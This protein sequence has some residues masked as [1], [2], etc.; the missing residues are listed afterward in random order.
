MKILFFDLKAFGPFTDKPIDLSKGSEGFHIIYGPNEAGKS[1][2]LRAIR[3]LFYG[4]HER[5]PD[6][7]L[8][9]G[10]KLRIGARIKHSDGSELIFQRRKGRT[11]TLL[12]END[13]PLDER[14]LERFLGGIDEALFAK[15]FGI[16]YDD[17][18]QGG[19]EIIAGHGDIGES[20]FAA[21]LGKGGLRKVLSE[22]DD[23]TDALFKPQA[24]KRYINIKISEFQEAKKETQKASLSSQDWDTHQRNL[25][26]AQNQKGNFVGRPN[27]LNTELNHLK[28]L[29]DVLP[30]LG[31]LKET[32]NKRTSM[33]DVLILSPEFPQ[34]RRDALQT[35]N[36]AKADA[37]KAQKYMQTYRLEL[38]QIHIPKN[39]I[40]MESVIK[41]L[42]Q[43]LGSH[44]KAKKDL[45]N[46]LTKRSQLLSDAE[47]I[48]RD[49]RPDITIEKVESIRISAPRR[50][51]IHELSSQHGILIEKQGNATKQHAIIIDKIDQAKKELETLGESKDIGE[52][53]EL[54][55]FIR[56]QGDMEKR[57]KETRKELQTLDEQ[58]SIDLRKLPLWTRDLDSL[59]ALTTPQQETIDRFEKSMSDQEMRLERIKIAANNAD[60][61]IKELNAD[62]QSLE[63]VGEIPTEDDLLRARERRQKG[64]ELIR[65]TWME[66][67]SVDAE[68]SVFDSSLPLDAAYEKSV[69]EADEISDRLRREADRVAQKTTWRAELKQHE[70]ELINYRAEEGIIR[71]GMIEIN[72]QWSQLWLPLGIQPLSP[73]E[74]RPWLISQQNLV[75][76]SERVRNAR[77]NVS[78]IEKEI[79]DFKSRLLTVFADLGE[80]GHSKVQSL[81]ILSNI[82]NKVITRHDETETQREFS[83]KILKDSQAQLKSVGDEKDNANTK[84]TQWQNEWNKVIKGIGFDVFIESSVVSSYIER[85]QQLF[86]KIDEASKLSDRIAGIERDENR[87]SSDVKAIVETTAPDLL[88]V[89]VEQAASMLDERYKEARKDEVKQNELLR[90]IKEKEQDL[91][92]ADDIIRENTRILDRLREQAK[93]SSYDE[94][95]GIERRSG[96][97]RE[98]DNVVHQLERQILPYAA[99]GT[100]ADLIEETAGINPDELPLRIEQMEKEIKELNSSISAL[101]QRIGGEEKEIEKMDGSASAAEAAEKAQSILAQL[102]EGVEQYVHLKLVAEILRDEIERYRSQHQGPI[103]KRASEIFSTITLGSFSGLKAGYDSEDRPVLIGVRPSGKEVGVEG[104]S[105]GTSDQLY[106]SLRLSSIE[107]QIG[108]GETLP[109]IVDDILVNFDDDRSRATLKI[110]TELSLKTQIIFFTHHQHLLQLAQKVIAPDILYIHN[111]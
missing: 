34:Q 25:R 81:N 18:I 2:A 94:M 75:H 12:N 61:K 47:N 104:M 101:D 96:E 53:R 6:T 66:G 8:H 48:L 35:L 78:L 7:F 110:L 43:R 71:Q 83:R 63:V 55:E 85:V 58:A 91:Q 86:E 73:K 89:T 39:I 56:G 69:N 108:G 92:S 97:A 93:C 84:I 79:E 65:R 111:I 105:D 31:D 19:K 106:L 98:L 38:E 33:G 14:V 10:T 49:I 23:K 87:F 88:L 24:Q 82:A 40:A 11:K 103:L 29:R 5:T 54:Y 9:E 51:Q 37:E 44:L 13:E 50:K 15:M 17:L 30:A 64:W 22:L 32:R 45:T 4:I 100:I 60:S 76:L 95:E 102:R 36:R 107:R 62:I 68:A 41:E 67:T 27:E 52:L 72:E 21:G 74:M 3:A 28:R 46:L 57:L 42:Q 80:T 1:A 109:F 20:L 59:E 90:Q 16:S 70:E 77:L 26:E 99:G